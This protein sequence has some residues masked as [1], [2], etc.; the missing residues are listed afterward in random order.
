MT[1]TFRIAVLSGILASVGLAFPSIVDAQR[2]GGGG[3]RGGGAVA[4][5][6]GPARGG[7]GAVVRGGGVY[8]G[9]H[10]AVPRTY[11]PYSSPYYRSYYSRGY[12]G[13][14]Y[15]SYPYHYR[16]YYSG[17]YPYYYSPWSFSLSFGWYGAGWYPPSLAYPSYYYPYSAYPAYPYPSASQPS[18]DA[19]VSPGTPDNSQ[20]QTA[21]TDDAGTF[22]TLLIRVVPSDATIVIDRHAWDGPRGD[23]HFSVELGAGPHEVEIRKAGYATYVRTIDVPRAR[24]LVLNV[25]LTQGGAGTPQVARTVPIRH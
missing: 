5:G 17:Y 11:P 21:R 22:G 13:H 24:A 14:G 3:G 19:M 1:R 25:S 23:E 6:G 15:Y 9:N 7:S 2:G 10:V 12:Y 18:Y 16:P 20:R 8:G 4:R